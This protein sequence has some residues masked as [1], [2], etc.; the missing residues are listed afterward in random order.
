MEDASIA[1]ISFE[2]RCTVNIQMRLKQ[3][4]ED[5]G[6]S[7]TGTGFF[8]R[9]DDGLFLITAKHNLTGKDVHGDMIGAFLPT[10]IQLSFYTNGEKLGENAHLVAYKRI[11]ISLFDLESGPEWFEHPTE[12][13]YDVAAI[14]LTPEPGSEGLNVH[15][16]NDKVQYPYEV[17]AG[18]DCFILGFPEALVGPGQTPIWKRASIASEPNLDYDG[19][20]VFLCDTATRKGMS[21]GPVYAKAIGQFSKEGRPLEPSGKPVFFGF[22]PIFIGIYAGRNGDE[23]TGFQ[24]GRIWKKHVVEDIVR[25]KVT[26]PHPHVFSN[27][28]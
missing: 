28:E 26:A 7:A 25:M 24:L 4:G 6:S 19:L 15:A 23:K 18:S 20:P 16:V 8:W 2:T 17:E 10:H 1:G 21:G 14:H 9:T 11:E 27:A 22:W 5:A 12:R 13:T 3:N